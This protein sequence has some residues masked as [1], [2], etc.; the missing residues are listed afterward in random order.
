MPRRGLATPQKMGRECSHDSPPKEIDE[1]RSADEGSHGS[2]RKLGRGYDGGRQRICNTPGHGAA[3]G[4]SGKQDAMIGAENETHDVGNKQANVANGAADGNSEAGKNGGSNVDHKA[5]A[6]NIHTK[7]H[8]F[9]F[10]SEK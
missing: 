3:K 9:F 1:E 8:G 5:H 2:H 10:A 4:S 7:M 6:T